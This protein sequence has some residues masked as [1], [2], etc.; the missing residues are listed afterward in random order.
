MH[1]KKFLIAVTILAF[2]ACTT[3]PP[4]SMEPDDLLKEYGTLRRTGKNYE[5]P[6][7]GKEIAMSYGAV[8]GIA[9]TSANGIAFVQVFEDDMSLLTVYLNIRP[10]KEKLVVW[11][12]DEAE[13][14]FVF[15]SEL[16][17]IIG[18]TRHGVK[19]E[20]KEGVSELTKVLIT[21]ETDEEPSVP[22]PIIAEGT[23][24]KTER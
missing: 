18:D 11:L 1:P 15:G 19:F 24:K 2:A 7:H 12:S 13:S 23:L 5:D 8:A 9:G 3:A 10:V 22:G 20:L 16:R 21:L 17:T 6:V 4:V 14:K